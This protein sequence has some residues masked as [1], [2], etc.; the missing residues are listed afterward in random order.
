MNKQF[1]KGFYWGASTAS[2]Q[3]SGCKHTNWASWEISFPR[4]LSLKK[5]GELEKYPIENFICGD[6]CKHDKRY[7]SDFNL[8]KKLGHNATRCGSEP[9][10][11]MPK[12]G[13]INKKALAQ[14][15]KVVKHLK[16]I[17]ITP[18]WN[19]W[20]WTIPDW[21]E[22]EGGWESPQALEYW[23]QY[24]DAII[25]TLGEDVEYWI[26]LNET[27]VFARFSYDWGLWPPQAKD[28]VRFEKVSNALAEAHIAAYKIIKK[29]NPNAKVGMAQNFGNKE[30]T[31]ECL[32]QQKWKIEAEDRWDRH[33]MEKIRSHQDFIGVNFYQRDLYGG[34]KNDLVN[35]LGWELW[36]KG[37]Y[38]TVLDVWR[39]YGKPIIITESGLA[40]K[41]DALRPWYL[42]ELLHW[43]H[44][45]IEDG[46]PVFGYLHWSLMDNFEWAY[47]F[48]PRFGLI[49]IDREHEL[50]RK[51]RKSAY[52]YRDIILKNGLT[53]ETAK[54]YKKLIAYPK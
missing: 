16:K 3:V 49:E 15:A 12:K 47:G 10:K 44:R 7:K 50:K 17:G 26:T 54:K 2:Y 27:N 19:L 35:D 5:T 32:E 30:M 6:A 1:P 39:W 14:Y 36:P 23:K 22:E 46:V 40:D 37:L 51:P 24:V 42:W 41:E 53:D 48:W 9:A 20:H 29:A 31:K 11:I 18:F 43:L 13:V 8:A 25:S 28:S 52:L 45:T 38:D 21:W 33:F 4:Y 34:N